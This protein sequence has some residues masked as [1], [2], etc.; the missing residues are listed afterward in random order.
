M[1]CNFDGANV[2]SGH[3]NGVQARIKIKQPGCVYLWCVAHRLELAVLDAIK[4]D[5]YLKDFEE[6]VN[7]IFKFYY[8]SPK[9]RQEIQDLEKV[10][11]SEFAQFGCMKKI[12]WITRSCSKSSRPKLYNFVQSFGKCQQLQWKRGPK[13]AR[14]TQ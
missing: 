4:N 3:L 2:M 11:D 1:C 13:G 10:F 8:K 12:R 14:I 5:S 6:T 7:S 9:L